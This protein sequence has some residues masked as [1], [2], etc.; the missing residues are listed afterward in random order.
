MG[1]LKLTTMGVVIPGRLVS[2]THIFGRG[3][4]VGVAVGAGTHKLPPPP[5][6]LDG[7]DIG[8]VL[9]A[10]FVCVSRVTYHTVHSRPPRAP[11]LVRWHVRR[12][13]ARNRPRGCPGQPRHADWIHDLAKY[14]ARRGARTRAWSHT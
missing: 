10:G 12:A 14:A 11:E 6:T 2:A 8:A 13:S 3:S 7:V 1:V 9:T 4:G 5:I